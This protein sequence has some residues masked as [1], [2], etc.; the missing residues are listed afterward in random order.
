MSATRPS[1]PSYIATVEWSSEA[2][3]AAD[4]ALVCRATHLMYFHQLHH[5]WQRTAH[6]ETVVTRHGTVGPFSC[7]RCG[8]PFCPFSCILWLSRCSRSLHRPF[9]SSLLTWHSKALYESSNPARGPPSMDSPMNAIDPCCQPAG[10]LRW[11][12]ADL[13]IG[14]SRVQFPV[15]SGP[16]N[17]LPR[18][19]NRAWGG[20]LYAAPVALQEEQ[21]PSHKWGCAYLER[22]FISLSECPS[23]RPQCPQ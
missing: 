18:C 12:S 21:E 19:G 23:P 13:E 7:I 8:C 2:A 11:E 15:S 14:R 17:E 5:Q 4:A 3:V 9:H 22:N 6:N 1:A 10:Q 20:L 16:R